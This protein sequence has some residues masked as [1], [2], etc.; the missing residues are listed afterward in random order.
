M[1][2]KWCILGEHKPRMLCCHQLQA[3]KQNALPDNI[4]KN[5]K[6]A[7]EVKTQGQMSP[8]T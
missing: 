7:V 3:T 4:C 5:T 8:K 1:L 2:I 6:I